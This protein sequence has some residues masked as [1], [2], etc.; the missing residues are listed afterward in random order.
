MPRIAIKRLF[1]PLFSTFSSPPP[2]ITFPLEPA[3]QKVFLD[4]SKAKFSFPPPRGKLDF[5]RR[6]FSFRHFFSM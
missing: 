2:F 5:F 3:R 4:R 1:L 6:H